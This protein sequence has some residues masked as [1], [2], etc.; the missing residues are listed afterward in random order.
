MGHIYLVVRERGVEN[1]KVAHISA[2][3]CNGVPLD[4]MLEAE[5][6]EKNRLVREF[7]SHR[8]S[9][10]QYVGGRFQQDSREAA[11]LRKGLREVTVEQILKRKRKR[12]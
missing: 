1:P 2:I 8:Y 6:V 4:L 12:G 3:A 11:Y 9:I 5:K 10:M 7:S